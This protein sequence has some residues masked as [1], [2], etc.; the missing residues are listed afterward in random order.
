VH[1]VGNK[2]EQ[3]MRLSCWYLVFEFHFQK[4]Y[5]PLKFQEEITADVVRWT[6]D[7]SAQFWT[8]ERAL[9]V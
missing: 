3:L 6:D 4:G 7:V 1:K 5:V 9:S 8:K 2:I